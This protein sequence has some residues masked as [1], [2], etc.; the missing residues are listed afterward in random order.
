MLKLRRTSRGFEAH[1]TTREFPYYTGIGGPPCPAG[2][3]FLG[4]RGVPKNVD[5]VITNCGENCHD[6]QCPNCDFEELKSLIERIRE[7][8]KNNRPIN[9]G[10]WGWNPCDRWVAGF[11]ESFANEIRMHPCVR[12][13][14][15]EQEVY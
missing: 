14:D 8:A 10:D 15:W 5:D 9:N 3:D 2:W 11:F 1:G 12:H 6:D 4:W 13:V 7:M